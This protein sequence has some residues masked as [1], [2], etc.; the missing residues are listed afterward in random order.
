MYQLKSVFYVFNILVFIT[1]VKNLN[2]FHFFI[3]ETKEKL[4]ISGKR[5]NL[6]SVKMIKYSK[7]FN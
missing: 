6:E 5:Q 3:S 2:Y 1:R 7:N 4:Q